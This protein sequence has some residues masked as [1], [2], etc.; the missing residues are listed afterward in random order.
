[1]LGTLDVLGDDAIMQRRGPREQSYVQ[2][3][4]EPRGKGGRGGSDVLENMMGG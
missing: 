1:M 2:V 3:R 4:G